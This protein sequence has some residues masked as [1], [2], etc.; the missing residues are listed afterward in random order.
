MAKIDISEVIEVNSD[1]TYSSITT[2]ITEGSY[3][4]RIEDLVE[5]LEDEEDIREGLKA[6]A[7]EEGA[8]TWEEYK[9][10]RK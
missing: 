6:L 7:E 10:K 8:I 9:L 2:P 1:G 3:E 5:L 4:A